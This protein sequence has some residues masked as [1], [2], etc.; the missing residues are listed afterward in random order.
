VLSQ[1]RIQWW[2]ERAWIGWSLAGERRPDSGALLVEHRRANPLINTRWLGPGAKWLRLMAVAASIRILLSEQAFGSVGLLTTLGML[3]D[4]MVTLNLIVVAASIAGIVV[5]VLTFRPD[6][7]ARPLSIAVI[8]IADRL[9][10]RR[11]RHQSHPA[12]RASI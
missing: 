6:N 1:G 3:N 2:T 11:R 12:E 8:L 4:Q 9:L 5:A 10:H 7:V